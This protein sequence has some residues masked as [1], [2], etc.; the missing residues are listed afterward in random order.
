MTK[1]SN[2]RKFKLGETPT[3][4]REVIL[5]VPMPMYER[6]LKNQVAVVEKG[7]IP[8]T[9]TPREFILITLANGV[10]LMEQ[11]LVSRERQGA[12]VVTPGEAQEMAERLRKVKR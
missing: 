11:D 2:N 9:M 8:A 4:Y 12:L 3:R 10:G 6:I 7:L 1:K 5:D